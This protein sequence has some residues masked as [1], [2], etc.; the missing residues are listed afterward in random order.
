MFSML[1]QR[2]IKTNM[3]SIVAILVAL[4]AT[5]SDTTA[6]KRLD[7]D[8]FHHLGNFLRSMQ[9]IDQLDHLYKPFQQYIVQ[10]S[11]RGAKETVEENDQEESLF[12]GL[13]TSYGQT[14]LRGEDWSEDDKVN[15]KAQC[16]SLI[17]L[18][19]KR[20]RLEESQEVESS[21]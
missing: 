21:L 8:D 12:F 10:R 1:E 11:V 16:T 5:T 20:R 7:M 17:K 9:K 4:L 18:M 2:K 14:D 15:V 3:F 6:T 13:F 19:N